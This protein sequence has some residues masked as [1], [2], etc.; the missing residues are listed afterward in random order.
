MGFNPAERERGVLVWSGWEDFVPCTSTRKA[1]AGWDLHLLRWIE[2]S[3]G[4]Y[5]RQWLPSNGL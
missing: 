5:R 2:R 3:V 4:T 1:R